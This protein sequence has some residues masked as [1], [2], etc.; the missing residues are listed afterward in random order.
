MRDLRN[1]DIRVFNHAAIKTHACLD[2]K[3]GGRV[4]RTRNVLKRARSFDDGFP[5]QADQSDAR[6][7]DLSL[8]KLIVTPRAE[9]DIEEA[10]ADLGLPDDT[11]TRIGRALRL[12]EDFPLA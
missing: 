3:R 2:V 12:L 11:W 8:A 6:R 10:I 4:S 9:R 7:F 5:G 1:T